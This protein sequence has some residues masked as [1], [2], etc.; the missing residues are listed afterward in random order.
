MIGDTDK[1]VN[2]S[3]NKTKFIFVGIGSAPFNC[4][5]DDGAAHARHF[6]KV[7]RLI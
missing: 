1:K 7:A 6:A 5:A 3:F 4:I 2:K